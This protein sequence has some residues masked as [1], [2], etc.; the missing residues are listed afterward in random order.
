M[1]TSILAC[2]SILE[3]PLLASLMI[4]FQ[5]IPSPTPTRYNIIFYILKQTWCPSVRPCGQKLGSAW[6]ILPITTRSLW[7]W[8]VVDGKI[9]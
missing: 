9:R 4:N 8:S 5:F 3:V 7:S 6:K 1:K 2:A